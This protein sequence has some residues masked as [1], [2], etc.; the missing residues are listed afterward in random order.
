M[1]TPS[2]IF[3][4]RLLDFVVVILSDDD[5]DDGYYCC[6]CYIYS[7]IPTELAGG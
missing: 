4:V 1:I 6:C 2:G 5:D 7:E 3:Q